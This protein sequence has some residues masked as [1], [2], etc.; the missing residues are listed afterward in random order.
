MSGGQGHHRA[1]AVARAQPRR[2]GANRSMGVQK[3]SGFMPCEADFLTGFLVRN[4]GAGKELL[5]SRKR[6]IRQ[7]NLALGKISHQLRNLS[8]I[9]VIEIKQ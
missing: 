4:L 3:L 8:S 5:C 6:G 9:A 1:V 7:I 2:A